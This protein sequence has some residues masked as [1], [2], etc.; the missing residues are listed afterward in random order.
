VTPHEVIRRT[1][2][3]EADPAEWTGP[4]V[5]SVKW[6][7]LSTGFS[8][9]S[10]PS[11][12]ALPK[13]AQNRVARVN[14]RRMDPSQPG[15]AGAFETAVNAVMMGSVLGWTGRWRIAAGRRSSGDRSHARNASAPRPKAPKLLRAS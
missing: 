14:R 2:G 9:I 8:A 4:I 7:G 5:Q 12:V 15:I 1:E 13:T 3:G 10:G 6:L 11:K